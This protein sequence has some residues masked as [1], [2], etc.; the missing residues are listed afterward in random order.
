MNNTYLDT[1]IKNMCNG[2]GVCALVCPLKC[3]KMEEDAEGFLY[4]I[5][6]EKKCIKCGKCKKNCSN[7]ISDNNYE[8]KAYAAKN[9]DTLERK[10]S[11]S[12]GMFK[13][14]VEY[15]INNNGVV[16]GVRMNEDLVAVH[17]WTEDINKCQEFSFSKYVRS[18][19]NNSYEKVKEFLDNGKLVLFSGTPCQVQGLRMFIG[20]ENEKL[21]L[22]EIICHA[23]PSPK[24]LKLYIRNNENK[25]NKKVKR[26]FFRS[27]N[28]EMDNGAYLE[29]EDGSKSK[30]DIY[31]KA[32]SGEQLINRPSCNNCQF[33]NENRKSDFTIGDFWGIEKIIPD[34][35]DKEGVS[36][37]TV[38]T[39]KA[40]KIFNDIRN[41]MYY[42]Q[43]DL[44]LAFK[45]NHHSNLKQNAN[46]EKFFK[47][48]SNGIIN[49]NNIIEY[50]KKYS[51]KPLYKKVL[52]KFKRI[53]KKIIRKE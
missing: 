19:L 40:N 30:D 29:F 22:C 15:V 25:H 41:K 49:E 9:K 2:C 13:I 42:K 45:Y 50:M 36:I 46:R 14:L 20:K 6:D 27:K 33:V 43:I 32:F 4:P 38:N 12:G 16:F 11:T 34:F 5:V 52:G 23:N 48:I 18:D 44:K 17:D 31:V 28:P 39:E 3:I 53:V 51:N 8:I 21:I 35:N 26:I 10:N 24:V 7:Y 1:K 47:G 37:L